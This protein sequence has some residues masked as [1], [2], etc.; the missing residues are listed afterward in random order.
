MLD[1]NVLVYAHRTDAHGHEAFRTWLEETVAGDAPFAVPDLV[2]ALRECRPSGIP[3][4]A[5]W[6]R[7][8]P[9]NDP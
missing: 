7:P 6:V 8:A 2:I 5:L 1:V 4:R 9:S 3:R